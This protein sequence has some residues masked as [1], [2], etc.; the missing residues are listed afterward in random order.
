MTN[1][2]EKL[3][4]YE[5]GLS[6]GNQCMAI[7]AGVGG[8]GAAATLAFGAICPLCFFVAPALVGAGL[9]K[10]ILEKRRFS[11]NGEGAISQD[12]ES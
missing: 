11:K 10:R 7:G 3:I 5:K 8:L 9:V 2:S 12:V 4:S 6:E 1:E